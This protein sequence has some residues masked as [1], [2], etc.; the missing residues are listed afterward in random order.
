MFHKN[1]LKVIRA[2]ILICAAIIILTARI[3]PL[4][5]PGYKKFCEITKRVQITYLTNICAV[6]SILMFSVGAAVS[7]RS[8]FF[9]HDSHKCILEVVYIR[10]VS[11]FLS[12][13]ITMAIGYWYLYFYDQRLLGGPEGS[14]YFKVNAI[15]SHMD[16][17]LPP[18]LNLTEAYLVEASFEFSSLIF[19]FII[20]LLYYTLIATVHH[21]NGVWPY[22]LF[23]NKSYL[24]VFM[25]LAVYLMIGTITSFL[26]LF[27]FK[28]IHRFMRGS[29]SK[30][31]SC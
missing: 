26:A 13:N 5:Q 29:K 31:Y 1:S 6:T 27:V 9:K 4:T 15:L 16:H 14:E 28:K 8:V 19:A 7:I 3:H 23:N 22:N 30:S 11:D 17:A 21:Y 24:K 20:L 10:A 25:I 12:A 18:I 2:T